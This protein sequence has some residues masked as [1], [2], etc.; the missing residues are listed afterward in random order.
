MNLIGKVI[1]AAAALFTLAPPGGAFA[2][3]EG[4]T[5]TTFNLVAG[6]AHIS[7]ADGNS[8][9]VWGY[10]LAG[11]P[12]QLPAPT[13]IVEQGDTVTVTLR[14]TLPEPVS[15][16]FPGQTGVSASGGQ[17]GTV[18]REAPPGGEVTY[19]FI[20][21]H[22][23]TYLYH[24][25]SHADVQVEM[26]LAG[27]LIVRPEGF[28]PANP[29]AYG[30][31]DSA[32]DH[33]YLFVLSE[34]DPR[35]HEA[36]YDGRMGDVDTTGYFPVYWLLNGRTAPDTLSAAF[37][38][39]LPHQPYNSLPRMRPG[40]KL[41][42]RVIGAGRDLHPFHHHGNH[43]LLIAR[44]GRLL[45]SAA[46]AGADLSFADFTVQTVPG[47]TY[48]AIFEWTGAGLGWDVY[49]HG[50]D[51]SDPGPCLVE[52]GEDCQ[53]HGRPFP[54]QLPSNQELTFGGHYSGS[55]FLG[56][57]GSLPPGEGGL[58]MNGG[59]FYMWHSHNEK[60]MTNYD[61]FP[62]GMMTMLI[63]EPPWVDIGHVSH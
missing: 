25:G 22:P 47:A 14:N 60:E 61:V 28:D 52:S 17:A 50:A 63:V 9:Y 11:K 2:A 32:Y 40:E 55:P 34:M 38:P 33:E 3:I 43:A 8:V 49:G 58:N 62:G 19:S 35:I 30:H 37:T 5:G 13:I 56:A 57:M 6:E 41:L 54:V 7:T 31:P 29:T 42:M 59:L 53:A 45:S 44:D 15:I 27:A 26:G 48:D 46:G 12:T 20:A 39:L 10:G 23:G 21:T 16:V 1:A 4:V 18:T 24:S 36:V 51:G